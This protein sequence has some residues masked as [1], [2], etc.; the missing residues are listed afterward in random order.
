VAPASGCPG[1]WVAAGLLA[2]AGIA[3]SGG[4]AGE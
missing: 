4:Q 2:R 1:V 3:L